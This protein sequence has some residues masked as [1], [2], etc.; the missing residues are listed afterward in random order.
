M[1]DGPSAIGKENDS[2]IRCGFGCGQLLSC[3]GRRQGQRRQPVG[4]FASGPEWLPAGGKDSNARAARQQ[5][6]G[7]GRGCVITCSQLS[8]ISSS[9]LFLRYASSVSSSGRLG[10][11]CTPQRR[12]DRGRHNE[13]SPS[14]A[15]PTKQTATSG[16]AQRGSDLQCRLGLADSSCPRQRDEPMFAHE[17]RNL[18]ELRLAPDEAGQRERQVRNRCVGPRADR[19]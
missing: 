17:R 12:G 9:D 18:V 11:S 10:T 2:A 15:S 6:H 1:V 7:N 14:G 13:G 8:R 5:T 16:I 19:D 3:L 4:A